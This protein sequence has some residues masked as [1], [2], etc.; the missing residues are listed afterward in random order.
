M[1][2]WDM[3][4]FSFGMKM[5]FQ[6]NRNWGEIAQVW[7][8]PVWQFVLVSCKR[9]LNHKRDLEWTCTNVK[10]S[11]VQ[12]THTL[13]KSGWVCTQ[14]LSLKLKQHKTVDPTCNRNKFKVPFRNIV[15][16]DCWNLSFLNFLIIL[17]KINNCIAKWR[18]C[19]WDIQ[20]LPLLAA[21]S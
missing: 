20:E 4:K 14:P 15:L 2:T 6:S 13:I 1:F 11:L 3:S 16:A 5:S 19:P 21:S 8:T 17:Q 10:V 7:F 18:L 9:I 12:C